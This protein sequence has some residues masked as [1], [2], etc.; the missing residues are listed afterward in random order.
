VGFGAAGLTLL[1][2]LRGLETGRFPIVGYFGVLTFYAL[3]ITM[4]YL[5]LAIWHEAKSLSIIIIP[6]VTLLLLLGTVRTETNVTIDPHVQNIWLD[7]HVLT[8]LIGYTLFTLA[9]VLAFFYLLQD[10]N[11]KRKIFGLIFRKLPALE[12]LDGL[13]HR[14]EPKLKRQLKA[15]TKGWRIQSSDMVRCEPGDRGNENCP[16]KKS[17]RPPALEPQRQQA[18]DCAVGFR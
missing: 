17:P 16:Q 5:Y 13:N 15:A 14:I 6:Y 3:A 10:R 8:T 12:T 4:G 2:I 7:M 18:T 11:L 1:L 9:C